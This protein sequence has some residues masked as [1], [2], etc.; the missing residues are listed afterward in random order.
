[1]DHAIPIKTVSGSA[2]LLNRNGVTTAFRYGPGNRA[3]KAFPI[4]IKDL[5]GQA[6]NQHI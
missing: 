3:R 6:D 1:M 2:V 4:Q 5:H